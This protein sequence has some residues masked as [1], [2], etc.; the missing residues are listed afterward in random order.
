MINNNFAL[1]NSGSSNALQTKVIERHRWYFYKEGFS[2]ALVEKAIE[3]AQLS[4]N[5]YALDPFN[6][7]GT[8][9]LT[10]AMNGI[11][12]IGFEVNPF[13]SFLAQTK[14]SN[15]SKETFKKS[16][17]NILNDCLRGKQSHLENY[18]TFSKN[19]KKGKYQWLFN[20]EVLRTFNGGFSKVN[21][22][23][24]KSSNLIKLA[25][26]SSAMQ[27]CNAKKDGKCLRY[28]RNWKKLIIVHIP[29]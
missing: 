17:E 3:E 23:K 8:V 11:K 24:S 5:D 6:G 25:L 14:A 28:K 16:V 12:S 9:T 29:F 26:I 19:D 4:D 20:Q 15:L 7:S 1:N 13:T 2:P 21:G 22:I 10:S 18:S 27:N